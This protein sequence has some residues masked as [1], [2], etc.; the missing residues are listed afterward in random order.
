MKTNLLSIGA[1]ETFGKQEV[2]CAVSRRLRT[3]DPGRPTQVI[4]PD[5]YY[6]D[7]DC[8]NCKGCYYFNRKP[9]E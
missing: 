4:C 6:C 3:N 9:K 1:A 5:Y 2:E 7:F 8:A